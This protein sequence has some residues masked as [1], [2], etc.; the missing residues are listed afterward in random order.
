MYEA[1]YYRTKIRECLDLA[2]TSS[3]PE[4]RAVYE[5]IAEEFRARL[6]ALEAPWPMQEG[7]APVREPV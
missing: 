6:T 3:E 4:C 5:A 7:V 1:D 2:N